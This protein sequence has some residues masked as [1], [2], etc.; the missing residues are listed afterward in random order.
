MARMKQRGPS[1]FTVVDTTADK[2]LS[3]FST[4]EEAQACVAATSSLDEWEIWQ[5]D[6]I[7]DWSVAIG[8][9]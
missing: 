4:L 1:A 5:G 9:D 8:Q 2:E 3:H 7:V 6:H